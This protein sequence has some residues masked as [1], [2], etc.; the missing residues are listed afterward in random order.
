MSQVGAN[1]GHFTKLAPRHKPVTVSSQVG[2]ENTYARH[3]GQLPLV[4]SHRDP[5]LVA[6]CDS[7]QTSILLPV[8][9]ETKLR[10]E[11]GVYF[12]SLH[13]VD[14]IAHATRLE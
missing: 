10:H 8:I 9:K 6:H 4:R 5:D 2:L 1:G 11:R 14:R 12:V 7:L 3:G 13:V